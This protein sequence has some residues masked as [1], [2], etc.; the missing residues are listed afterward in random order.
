MHAAGSL[1]PRACPVFEAC[2]VVLQTEGIAGLYRGL[3]GPRSCS[4]IP[5]IAIQVSD[6]PLLVSFWFCLLVLQFAVYESLRAFVHQ[7]QKRPSSACAAGIDLL[8]PLFFFFWFCL[9]ALQFAV[10]ENLR[11]FVRE[12]RKVEKL[13]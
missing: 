6:S 10:Y 7:N 4:D 13:T 5:E 11:S 8:S 1:V 3:S 12:R 2:K 9:S